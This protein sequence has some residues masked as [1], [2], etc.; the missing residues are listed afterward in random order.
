MNQVIEESEQ[1]LE[2][3]LGGVC[4]DRANVY[5]LLAKAV[6]PPTLELAES[7]INRNFYSEVEKSV[8]WVNEREGMYN[9][10]LEKLKK[11]SENEK[12]ENPAELLKEMEEEYE[13]LF[14]FAAQNGISPYESDYGDKTRDSVVASVLKAYKGEDTIILSKAMDAPDHISTELEFLSHLSRLEGE[15]WQKGQMLEAKKWRIKERTFIVH[16]LRSWGASFFDKFE[17]SAEL[18]VYKAIAS[19]GSIFL[20]I[21]YGN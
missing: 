19:I 2:N 3:K 14:P 16:H 4:L 10:S 12:V 11:A 8:Q 18:E 7:L 20:T 1:F 13:K 6:Q 17:Q 5:Q 21:E 9:R 15:A